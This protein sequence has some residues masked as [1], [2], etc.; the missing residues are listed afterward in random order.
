MERADFFPDWRDLVTFAT[1]HPEPTLLRDDS[2]LRVLVEGLEPG[3]T[4]PAHPERLAVDHILEGRGEM[5]VDTRRFVLAPG[6]TMIAPR[7]SRRGIE[8]RTR[9]AF[10]AVRVGPELESDD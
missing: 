4:I 1:P 7:G 10:L 8:A 2:D 5:I 3:G 6:T 9:L